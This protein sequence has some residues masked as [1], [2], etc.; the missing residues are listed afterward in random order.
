MP[1]GRPK[2]HLLV[3]GTDRQTL[4]RFTGRHLTSQSLAMRARIILQCVG[5]Q[6]NTMVARE[7]HDT[8]A[9]VGKRRTRFITRGIE[10]LFDER[11][12]G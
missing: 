2:A 7:L 3:S 10:G 5:G 12:C 8:D 6:T 4:E 9:T 1:A 11:R